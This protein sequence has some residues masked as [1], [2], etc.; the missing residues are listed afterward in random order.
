MKIIA[1]SNI[2]FAKEAFCGIGEVETVK[3]AELSPERLRDCD[4]LLCRSTRRIGAELLEGTNV[5]FVATATIGTDHFDFDY[6]QRRGIR[7]ASAPGCNANSV[8]EYV[9]SA[10]LVLAEQKERRLRQMTLGVVGVGNVG[11]RVV[12]KA[13][14]LGMNVLQNDPPLRWLA[15]GP[16]KE[17]FRPIEELMVADVI[18][19]HVPLTRQGPD[20]TYH[21]VS[22][23][24]LEQVKPGAIL[25]NSSRGAVAETGALH[26]AIDSGRLAAAVLDVW[27]NE[28]LIDTDLLAKVAIGTP[29]I[30]GHSF[31]G[32]VDGTRMVYEAVCDFLGL[33]PGWDPRTVL[34]PPD[35]PRIS[36][37]ALRRDHE[38][39]IREAV[40]TLYDLRRDDAELRKTPH[41]EA[42]G[43]YFSSL[44]RNYWRRRA[45]HN[46]VIDVAGGSSEL[47]AR[48]A[49]LGFRL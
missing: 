38:D 29:H 9:T 19:F 12:K 42:R 1:D 15:S 2:P 39:V 31:D 3:A 14:A 10:L 24:F 40:L 7:F 8:S 13:E 45:F 49:G 25:I 36:L 47:R 32:K 26:R 34:P 46:T 35:V 5:R 41:G 44:R 21:M 23:A 16:A 11:G 43:E 20:A 27:E 48:L 6:L 18:T 4:I 22:D 30:A 37:D 28:P 17:R 33:Q